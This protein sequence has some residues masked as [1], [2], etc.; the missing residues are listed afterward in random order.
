[1]PIVD[2]FIDEKRN[3]PNILGCLFHTHCSRTNVLSYRMDKLCV[4]QS[5]RNNQFIRFYKPAKCL[6]DGSIAHYLYRS[7]AIKHDHRAHAPFRFGIPSQKPQ[8]HQNLEEREE[9]SSQ[10]SRKEPCAHVHARA[11][12]PHLETTFPSTA[13]KLHRD[14]TRKN[15]SCS[16]NPHSRFHNSGRFPKARLFA[17]KCCAYSVLQPL[18]SD[19]TDRRACLSLAMQAWFSPRSHNAYILHAFIIAHQ[20]HAKM[21]KC[22]DRRAGAFASSLKPISA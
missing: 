1:M 10:S 7:A 11:A 19:R 8:N 12:P 9:D 17:A 4:Q 15:H 18:L 16:Q 13:R 14:R 2:E 3:L 20:I 5:W 6:S 22:P 21:P